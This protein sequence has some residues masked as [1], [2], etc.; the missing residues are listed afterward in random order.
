M[1]FFAFINKMMATDIQRILCAVLYRLAR[2]NLK[3]GRLVRIWL[4]GL[5]YV[6]IVEPEDIQTVLS[7]RK[8]TRKVFFYKLLDNFLGK[9]LITRDV[10]TWGTH[11]K[12]LQP[13]F[14]LHILEKFNITFAKCAHRLMHEF[15][16]KD[17]QE[18]NITSFINDSV[19][20]ILS[21]K[22]IPAIILQVKQHFNN[23]F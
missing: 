14:H 18:I 22:F 1:P 10:E 9:G 3:Y 15:L 16:E 12:F 17:N 13:A 8:H 11:R 5:P 21:G 19:Y 20:D 6:I 4:T 23:Q 2:E 7:S